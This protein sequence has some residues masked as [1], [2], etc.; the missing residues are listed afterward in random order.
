[1]PEK[2]T[3]DAG[4]LNRRITI[5]RPV[6]IQAEDGTTTTTW[7]PVATDIRA[8]IEPLSVRDFIAAQSRQSK[9]SVRIVIRYRPGLTANMRIV[10]DGGSIFKPEGWQPDPITGREWLTAPCSGVL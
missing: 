1:M 2:P 9:I 6:L 8:G 10:T 4:R 3:L 7:T 5:E